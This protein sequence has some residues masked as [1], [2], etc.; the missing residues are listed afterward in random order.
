MCGVI[1]FPPVL[2]CAVFPGTIPVRKAHA[3][4]LVV[5]FCSP[6]LAQT[7]SSDLRQHID[8]IASDALTKTGVPSASIAVVQDGK[9]A[10]LQAYGNARL[11]PR[12]PARPDQRYNIGS[13]SKQFTAAAM[14][15][16]Q[17]QGK[18]SLD[19]KVAN[20]SPASPAPTKSVFA[21]CS[22]IPPAIR[23]TGRR[24]T[25]CPHAA[26]NHCGQDHGWLGAQAAR[27]RP[28]LQM[29]VQQHQFRDRGR[30]RRKASGMP[31]LQFLRE[32]I[33]APLGMKSVANIDQDRLADTDPDRLRALRAR[34]AASRAQGR[35]GLAVR[36]R[37]TGHAR[38]RSRPLGHFHDRS[39]GVAAIFLPA[40]GNRSRC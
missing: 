39:N 17:E 11:D 18:L 30:D 34:S 29:A 24:T 12:T 21:S 8:A 3:L 1:R 7:I 19:D 14:L 6:A 10:Y 40:A 15:L 5:A 23:T 35:E 27:F 4:I 25:C 26:A 36:R 20:S 2:H 37:R 13:I 9:I 31:L 33:F 38:R 22:L 16:L 32:K 28:R